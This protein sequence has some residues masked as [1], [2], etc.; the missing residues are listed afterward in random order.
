MGEVSNTM[1][2]SFNML[3]RTKR[4]DVIVDILSCN[5]NLVYPSYLARFLLQQLQGD[6]LVE[7]LDL[8]V[9]LIAVQSLMHKLSLFAMELRIS[10]EHKV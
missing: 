2:V 1:K 7:V 6:I 8:L 3:C 10:G 5:V 4:L 9:P